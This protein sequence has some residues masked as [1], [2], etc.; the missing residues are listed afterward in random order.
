MQNGT[1]D[2]MLFSEVCLFR[3]GRFWRHRRLPVPVVT[4]LRAVATG[5]SI[6]ALPAYRAT[7]CRGFGLEAQGFITSHDD[8]SRMLVAIAVACLDEHPLRLH[9]L[10]K[11]KAG[12]SFAAVVRGEQDGGSELGVG[13]NQLRLKP[14]TQ[15]PRQ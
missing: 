15:I 11:R 13:T 6:G 4:H 5:G 1:P 3:L 9:G 12:G 10:Q 7:A 2:G 14:R 8:R